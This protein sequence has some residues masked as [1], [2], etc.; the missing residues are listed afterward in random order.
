MGVKVGVALGVWL[1]VD[2]NVKVG[3]DV[4]VGVTVG[5]AVEV[6]VG[7][8]V[9]VGVGV[10]VGSTRETVIAPSAPVTDGMLFPSV[11]CAIVFVLTSGYVPG[12]VLARMKKLQV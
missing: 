7:V 6:G 10:F 11:S 3:V 4:A 1:G 8:T 9:G 12:G 2:V 5:V